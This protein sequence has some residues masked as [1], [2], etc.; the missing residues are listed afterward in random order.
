MAGTVVVDTVKS[1]TTGAPTFQNTSGTEIG[2]LCRAWVNFNGTSGSTYIRASFNVSS[3]TYNSTGDY[4]VNFTNP[5][6]DTN[7]GCTFGMRRGTTDS[8]YK[9]TYK[10]GGTL[11]TSAVQILGQSGSGTTVYDAGIA[12]VAVFR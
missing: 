9:L 12:I 10:F 1:S 6:P 4:T 2:T 7:Y 8:N 3:I 5:M 11:T